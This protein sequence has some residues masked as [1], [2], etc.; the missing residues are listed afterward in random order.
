M[1]CLQRCN[2]VNANAY[3][4]S[5][6]GRVDFLDRGKRVVRWKQIGYP[7]CDKSKYLLLSSYFVPCTCVL[8]SDTIEH[9]LSG[10]TFFYYPKAKFR[11]EKHCQQLIMK[12]EQTFPRRHVRTTNHVSIAKS[13]R[14]SSSRVSDGEMDHPTPHIAMDLDFLN[15]SY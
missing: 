12:I 1:E 10:R 15:S 14:P 7:L 3:S 13:L 11:M 8:H 9:F 4:G 2:L 5:N 6:A